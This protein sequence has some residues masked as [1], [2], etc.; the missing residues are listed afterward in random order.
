VSIS[1]G[2]CHE[3]H[4]PLPLSIKRQ[5]INPGLSGKWPITTACLFM[6]KNKREK[7]VNVVK[8]SKAAAEM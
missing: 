7:I 4:F 3:E 5:P 2:Y 1:P 8:V 6:Q